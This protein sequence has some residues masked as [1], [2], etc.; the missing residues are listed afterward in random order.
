[1]VVL[2]A[3][4]VVMVDV[5]ETLVL[6]EGTEYKP[7]FKVIEQ[8]IRHKDRGH[9]VIVWS[10]GGVEW[11]ARVVKELNL[12]HNVDVVMNKPAFMWDDKNPLDWTRLCYAK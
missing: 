6:W 1:M 12:E 5:D 9:Y 11:A 4:I 2:K 3:P 8:L 10:A 7:N